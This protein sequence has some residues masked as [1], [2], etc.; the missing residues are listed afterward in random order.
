[1][2]PRASTFSRKKSGCL[3]CR[4]RKKKCDERKP[5]CQSCERNYLLCTWPLALPEPNN[6]W[7]HSR[8]LE[9]H[10]DVETLPTVACS[11]TPEHYAHNL[12][13][14]TNTEGNTEEQSF[15]NSTNTT[16]G[17]PF[18][19]SIGLNLL[20]PRDWFHLTL[21]KPASRTLFQHYESRTADLLCASQGLANPFMSLLIPLAAT[22]EPILQCILA[23]SGVHYLN[24]FRGVPSSDIIITTWSHYALAIR[25]LKHGI[26]RMAYGE[27]EIL[28]LLIATLL[29]CFVEVRHSRQIYPTIECKSQLTS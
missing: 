17:A 8:L 24:H 10:L 4:L 3:A 15:L 27:Q 6:L 25:G 14:R 29:F 13:P 12:D 16:Q 22:H 7:R 23:L 5:R 18:S 11:E 9:K 21:S 28:P 2:S 19:I 1:M 26:T 20:K